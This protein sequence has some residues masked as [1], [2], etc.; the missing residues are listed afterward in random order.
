MWTP[1]EK[2]PY[3]W[4]G[5]D[6]IEGEVLKGD[7]LRTIN[8][9]EYH[10]EKK[11]L[12][13]P[14][15]GLYQHYYDNDT[16]Q[17]VPDSD[18]ELLQ[19]P[20]L[21]HV[22]L[23]LAWS[24][25]EPEEG[26][27]NWQWIDGLVERWYERYGIKISICITS[28]ET[29]SD[30]NKIFATPKWV[31]DAG[32]KGGFYRPSLNAQHENW[33]PDYND[34][35]FLEKLENFHRALAERY[36]GKPYIEEIVTGS[37]G[38]YGEG[39]SWSSGQTHESYETIKN[40]L[41]MYNRVY[42]GYIVYVNDDYIRSNCKNE[43]ERDKLIKFCIDNK[44]GLRDDGVL[45]K[46]FLEAAL[47]S[48]S[49]ARPDIFWRF[50]PHAPINMES[51]HYRYLLKN[52]IWRGKNGIEAG[53]NILRGAIDIEMPTFF[54]YHGYAKLWYKDNPEFAAEIANKVGYWYFLDSITLPDKTNR[55]KDTKIGLS[56]TNKGV[57]RGYFN[58]DTIIR[59]E[60]AE[61]CYDLKAEGSDNTKWLAY[62]TTN[63]IA[64]I[65]TSAV[66]PGKYKLKLRLTYND[67]AGEQP[68]LLAFND[69]IMDA[70]G[71]YSLAEI[72]VN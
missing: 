54:G 65:D 59:L 47:T 60:G 22:Y 61:G 16:I 56:W 63:E 72:K 18:E 43:G 5:I 44:I 25:L 38:D 68:V 17:Y 53:A 2:R 14:R 40:H 12:K 58:F 21:N 42:K 31:I 9:K 57:A 19:V 50:A 49:V 39:H 52:D 45:I 20:G 26:V 28:K 33:R 6:N 67:K 7:N 8:L 41:E 55:Q 29:G 64:S 70:D 1:L 48:Y 62:Q 27:Y 35:I 51:C 10:D 37:I 69:E 36:F 32:A 4:C 15:K 71:Y 13:N 11:V 30:P 24:H 3:I 23:R 46:S 66:K 34:P